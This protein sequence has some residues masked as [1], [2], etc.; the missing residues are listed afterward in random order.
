LLTMYLYFASDQRKLKL[1]RILV[2][3]RL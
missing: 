3:E 1:S 2:E